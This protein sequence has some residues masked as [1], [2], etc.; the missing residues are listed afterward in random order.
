MSANGKSYIKD[1]ELFSPLNKKDFSLEEI[2]MHEL[3]N[4]RDSL[5]WNKYRADSLDKK[6]MTTY[7]VMDSI[8]DKRKFDAILKFS[9]KAVLGRIPIKF[10]DIR[11]I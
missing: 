3:A 7:E 11:S 10:I 5:F 2:K 4:E 6:E 1:V 9:E 8:G